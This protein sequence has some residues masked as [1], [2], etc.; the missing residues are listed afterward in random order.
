MPAEEQEWIPPPPLSLPFPPK[1]PSSERI[2]DY[3]IQPDGN[4]NNVF[5]VKHTKTEVVYMLEFFDDG[6]NM[7]TKNDKSSVSKREW[8]LDCSIPLESVKSCG[9]HV[10]SKTGAITATRKDPPIQPTNSTTNP[11]PN[12][13]NNNKTNNNN[14]KPA[15]QQ[16]Q[17]II[18][19][20]VYNLVSFEWHKGSKQIFSHDYFE[21]FGNA[22][23]I[24]D[25]FF[26]TVGFKMHVRKGSPGSVELS[27]IS[28]AGGESLRSWKL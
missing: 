2:L 5:T 24:S 6:I 15:A 4:L 3:D 9:A 27:I 17:P 11:G 22:K 23:E 26:A 10:R 8:K 1:W 25:S 13:N 19:D 14:N 20:T 12:N 18:D 7:Y 28:I 16:I 21:T